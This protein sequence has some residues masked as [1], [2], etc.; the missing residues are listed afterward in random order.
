M[1]KY[2]EILLYAP[3]TWLFYNAPPYGALYTL[4]LPM[5]IMAMLFLHFVGFQARRHG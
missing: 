3:F 1:G 2:F 5:A 4:W